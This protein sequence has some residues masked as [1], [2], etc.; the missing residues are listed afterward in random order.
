MTITLDTHRTAVDRF[1]LRMREDYTHHSHLPSYLLI[2]GEVADIIA[3][4][5][6]DAAAMTP[7]ADNVAALHTA[8]MA[9]I[10]HLDRTDNHAD[11]I[12]AELGVVVRT[13]EAEFADQF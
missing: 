3:H 12:A 13:L 8:L 7:R 4:A 9:R 10:S 1:A 6:L 5:Q 11:E 2:G